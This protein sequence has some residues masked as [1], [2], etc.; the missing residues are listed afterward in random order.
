[1]FRVHDLPDPTR[2]RELATFVSTF[3]YSLHVDGNVRSKDFQK[4]LEAVKGSD[5]ENLIN[6]VAIRSMAKA[7][8]SAKNIGHYGLAFDTYTHFT[9][10]IRRYPDLVV[11][12]LMKEYASGMSHERRESLNG[13]VPVVAKHTSERERVAMEAER[14]AIKVMQ[15]SFMQ[16]HVGD[17]FPAVVSGVTKFGL[18]VE[19]EELLVE[20]MVH[21]RDLNDDF[22]VYDETKYA[23]IG[24]R[25]DRRYRLGDHLDVQ[26]VKVN[27]EERQI[28]FRIVT[29]PQK[30]ATESAE[31]RGR[32]RRR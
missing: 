4:L 29:R 25:T 9:S 30:P 20:G 27:P 7:E 18:F 11:H 32:R 2:I 14:A 13:L 12:R 8:Y 16:R 22:Y 10:P 31:K 3:G 19:I 15:V 1:M 17:T 28:D 6:E 26:V 24:R 23:L 21:V 5:V